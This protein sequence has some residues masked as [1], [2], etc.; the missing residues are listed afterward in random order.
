MEENT[1]A[2][3]T[4]VIPRALGGPTMERRLRISEGETKP[5][6]GDYISAK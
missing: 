4:N 1:A 3:G 6:E 5:G 2:L